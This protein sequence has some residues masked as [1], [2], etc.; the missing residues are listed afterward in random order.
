MLISCCSC[1]LSTPNCA[2]IRGKAG[3]TAS[4][5]NGP[6]I[7]RPASST[8]RLRCTARGVAFMLVKRNE[9][10]AKNIAERMKQPGVTF[11]AVGAGHLAGPDSLQ[12][13]LEKLG[14]EVQRQ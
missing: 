13:Q 11:V 1:A 9:A 10:W 12:K 2:P 3:N 14:I 6:I 5:E 8:G 4:I 7:D